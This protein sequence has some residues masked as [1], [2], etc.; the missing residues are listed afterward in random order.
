M[1]PTMCMKV[2]PWIWRIRGTSGFRY[3]S[4]FVSRLKNLSRPARKG[5]SP[6]PILRTHHA[7]LSCEFILTLHT[8]GVGRR[9]AVTAKKACNHSGLPVLHVDSD[10]ELAPNLAIQQQEWSD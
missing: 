9:A 1:T 8:D 3:I 10:M 4:Q 5:P 7:C 2:T 6:K